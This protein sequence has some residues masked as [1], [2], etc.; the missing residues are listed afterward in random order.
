[1]KVAE[2]RNLWQR[3]GP[4]GQSTAMILVGLLLFAWGIFGA[5]NADNA[6]DK[7]RE[8]IHGV[9]TIHSESTAARQCAVAKQ[10]RFLVRQGDARPRI[11]RRMSDFV[12]SACNVVP[13]P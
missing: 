12:E 4:T 7:L 3:L 9:V 1:M 2:T 8:Q 11:D 6:N 13:I 5:I 10:I